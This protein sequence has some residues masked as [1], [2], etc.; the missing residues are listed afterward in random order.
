MSVY[1]PNGVYWIK[2]FHMGKYR[3]IEIDDR[4]P[5]NKNDDLLTPRC[6]SLEEIWPALISKALLKLFSY[7]YK[8]HDYFCE[9]IGDISIM[10]ALTGYIGETIEIMSFSNGMYF[11][12]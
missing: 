11:H 9:E 4:M 5:C 10:Y 7:K 1:N 3:K 6:E 8:Q 12:L 2:L